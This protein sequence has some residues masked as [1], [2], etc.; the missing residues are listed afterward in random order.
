[1]VYELTRMGLKVEREKSMPIAY[2]D[3][4]IDHGYRMDIL[5]DN[6]L[7]V[8]LKTV[9]EISPVHMAQTLTYMRLGQYPLGLLINFHETLVKNGIRRLINPRRTFRTFF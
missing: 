8:E 5:V 6:T 9:E 3:L 7:V 1:M 4:R 2:E